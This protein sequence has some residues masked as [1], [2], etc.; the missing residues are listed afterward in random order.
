ME[1]DRQVRRQIGVDA[2]EVDQAATGPEVGQQA[3]EGEL[4]GH[5]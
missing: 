1:R 2:A 5:G 3:L 4:D